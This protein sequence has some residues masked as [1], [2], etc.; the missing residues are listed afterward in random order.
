[1]IV[2]VF[3]QGSLDPAP[4][5]AA[6]VTPASPPAEAASPADAAAPAEG[7]EPAATGL[8]QQPT[9][10]NRRHG[11]TGEP[12]AE[13]EPVKLPGRW[14]RRQRL[15][16]ATSASFASGECPWLGLA[17]NPFGSSQ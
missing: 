10:L 15:P 13:A 2:Y 12:P 17:A 1:M 16:K 8:N 9:G 4:A 3:S 5:A 6:P 11:C 7:T 14:N